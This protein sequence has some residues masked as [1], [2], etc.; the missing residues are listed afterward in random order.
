MPEI[1]WRIPGGNPEHCRRDPAAFL[2]H[3]YIRIK[4][5]WQYNRFIFQEKSI[6]VK[7]LGETGN[8]R[9]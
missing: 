6:K 7:G 9:I 4:P 8:D 1:S 3:L 5:G 2:E